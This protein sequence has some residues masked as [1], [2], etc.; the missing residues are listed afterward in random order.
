MLIGMI[1]L[2][3]NGIVLSLIYFSTG[4]KG[5]RTKAY[6]KWALLELLTVGWKHCDLDAQWHDSAAAQSLLVLDL[7]TSSWSLIL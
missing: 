4:S 5:V 1:L 6:Y 7:Y 2:Q 3:H